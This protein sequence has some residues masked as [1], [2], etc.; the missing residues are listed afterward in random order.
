MNKI[1]KYPLELLRLQDIR[2]EIEQCLSVQ[3]QDGQLY[4]WAIVD[5]NACVGRSK[6]MII[7]TGDDVPRG[8][9]L[10]TTHY[11]STVQINGFVWH[12]FWIE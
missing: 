10:S 5:E 6:I 4:L 1:Y 12:F 7:G 3:I 9:E 8:D 11:I 2:A